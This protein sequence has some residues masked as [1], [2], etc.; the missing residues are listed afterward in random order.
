MA[1]QPRQICKLPEPIHSVVVTSAD[2]QHS[3]TMFPSDIKALIAHLWAVSS[4]RSI[5]VGRSC[6]VLSPEKDE[7][8]RI[9]NPRCFDTNP[10]TWHLAILNKVG[11]EK[12]SF[13]MDSSSNAEKWNYTIDSYYLRYFNPQTFK[14]SRS[15]RDAL[16]RTASY[17]NDP[18]KSHRSANSVYILGVTMDVF[19]PLSTE[20]DTYPSFAKIL[21]STYSVTYD[22]ELDAKYNVIG[23]EW[24][25]DEHPDFLW[26]F[27][28]GS[29]AMVSQDAL[30][31]ERW[32]GVSAMSPQW[33]QAAQTAS[34][35]GRVLGSI[36]DVLIKKSRE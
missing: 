30:L 27:P 35:S 3:I 4:P 8:G 33:A 6:G 18:F 31:T 15:W 32:D 28:R 2:G 22:L 7:Y 1:G 13:I 9:A 29:R 21:Y 20:P 34:Q 19:Y 36:V 25:S 26:T 24:R 11:R 10:M 16:V 12:Q 23:G 14:P 5:V 17:V